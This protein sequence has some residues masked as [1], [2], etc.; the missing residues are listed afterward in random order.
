MTLGEWSLIDLISFL[1]ALLA[2]WA[3]DSIAHRY[4][5]S[6]FFRWGFLRE[7]RFFGFREFWK[8]DGSRKYIGGDPRNGRKKFLG[9]VIP[10]AFFDGWHFWKM[11]MVGSVI[12]LAAA[13]VAQ[14][15]IYSVAWNLLWWLIYDL[16][17]HTGRVNGAKDIRG[18]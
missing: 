7:T 9:I 14:Y 18:R 3:M 10:P 16:N 6:I 12:T 1:T 15:V 11:I 13:N 17:Y 5:Q 2:N 8:R 4:P